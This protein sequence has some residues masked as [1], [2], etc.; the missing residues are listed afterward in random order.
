MPNQKNGALG[1][2][3]KIREA[4]KKARKLIDDTRRNKTSKIIQEAHDEAQKVKEDA[5]T[6]TRKESGKKKKLIIEKAAAE[7][8]KIRQKA[9]E[10]A[11]KLS[12]RVESLMP[13]AVKKVSGRIRQH[14]KGRS[15]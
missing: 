5:L 1:S 15:A 14:L 6:K 2:L 12:K 8:D 10:E 7:A 13:E 11:E 9:D 3:Q 4:E